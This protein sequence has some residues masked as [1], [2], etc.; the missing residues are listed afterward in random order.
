MPHTS[1]DERRVCKL[2]EDLEEARAWRD[3]AA[4]EDEALGVAAVLRSEKPVEAAQIYGSLGQC[5]FSLGKY[6]RA[7]Q[8]VEEMRAV[9]EAAGHRQGQVAAAGNLGFILSALGQHD[10][11][12]QVQEETLTIL[13]ELGD[14][15]GQGA[16]HLNLGN[17]FLR[18]ARAGARDKFAK[19]IEQLE[20]ARSVM[21]ELGNVAAQGK[22]CSS[23]GICYQSLQR[24]DEAVGALNQAMAIASAVGNRIGHAS[25]MGNLGILYNEMGQHEKAISLHRAAI[26]I[27]EEVGDIAHLARNHNNLAAALIRCDRLEEACAVLF[28]SLMLWLKVERDVGAHDDRR[29]SLF[30]EIQSVFVTLQRVLLSQGNP[31]WALGVS[32]KAKARALSHRIGGRQSQAGNGQATDSSSADELTDDAP[33]YQAIC[34]AWWGEVQA[35]ARAEGCHV[36]IV[37]FSLVAD[38]LAIWVLSGDGK[39][40]T[41]ATLPSVGLGHDKGSTIKQ[42]LADTRKSM[43]VRGRD[44]RDVHSAEP[45]DDSAAQVDADEPRANKCPSCRLRFAECECQS[46]AREETLLRELHQVLI[47]PVEEALVGAEEIL[48]IPHKELFEVPWAA[49]LD[50]DGHYLIQR[51]VI[52]VAP[53]LRVARQAAEAVQPAP[54]GHVVVL[55]NP[56]PLPPPFRTLPHAEEEAAKVEETL[57]KAG[58]MVRDFFKGDRNPKATKDRV[59]RALQ[60]SG[61]SHLAC[62]GDLDTDSLVLALPTGLHLG[63]ETLGASRVGAQYSCDACGKLCRTLSSADGPRWKCKDCQDYDLCNRCHRV[64]EAALAA[65]ADA[66]VRRSAWG[67]SLTC[68]L[69]V[70]GSF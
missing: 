38:F 12:A 65:D 35:L 7:I 13:E 44:A 46:A 23:L 66:Q 2:V 54:N 30:E 52:R 14:R 59:K 45:G 18:Q 6:D 4:M 27:D 20:K 55:G 64:H 40:L 47:A 11:A 26:E 3:L 32:S 62:H 36:R 60:G 70:N 49:L 29:V 41:S 68:A 15:E 51:H 67:E 25:A 22:A 69:L 56:Q 24:Y 53:S 34:G 63:V 61:W 50:S 43:K 10:R 57:N 31:G 19:A 8:M 5:A 58:I 48:I 28:R 1:V 37:E 9:M 17:A 39:L 33:D 21:G 42:L 16:A